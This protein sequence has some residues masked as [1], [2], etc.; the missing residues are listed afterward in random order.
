[1][2][3]IMIMKR[4]SLCTKFFTKIRFKHSQRVKYWWNPFADTNGNK[5]I[6]SVSLRLVQKENL[7]SIK[8]ITLF[9]H[10]QF[11]AVLRTQLDIDNGIF[12]AKI[13][14]QFVYIV[15]NFQFMKSPLELNSLFSF[16]LFFHTIWLV[17]STD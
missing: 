1:M 10:T 7:Q 8:Y 4:K 2:I 9:Q 16:L 15:N 3:I 11:R 5:Y 12:F 17:K 14:N 13:V 6:R